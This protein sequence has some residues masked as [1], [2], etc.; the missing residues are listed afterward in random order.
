MLAGAAFAKESVTEAA[1]QKTF[2]N[3]VRPFV[4]TYCIGCHGHEKPKGDFDLSPFTSMSAVVADFKHWEL[5]LERLEAKEMPPKK[6]EK[7]P[8]AAQ[9]KEITDW[10]LALRRFE[11]DRNAGDPG[12]VLARRLSNAEYDF[13]IRDLTGV[14]IRPTR[15]FPVDPANQAGFDNSGESLTMSPAL[16]KKYLQAAKD[17]SDHLLLRPDGLGFAPHPVVT[18]TDRD[19]YCIRQIVDFYLRQP[20][21]FADYFAAAWR[22]KNRSALGKSRAAIE[23]IAADAKV[24]PK[25]LA[26]VWGALIAK[27]EVGPIAKLQTM[28]RELPPAKRGKEPEELRAACVAMRDFVVDVREKIK[29][30]VKNLGIPGVN[31]SAQ[32][33][34]LWKDRQMAA[35]RTKYDP[36]LLQIDGAVPQREEDKNKGPSYNQ[37]KVAKKRVLPDENLF[38][39]SAERAKYEAAFARFAAIFP[40]A[41]YVKE[42]G[43]TFVDPEEEKANGNVGRL[44]SAGLHNQTGY[45]RDDGPLYNMVLDAKGQREL[46]QLWDEFNLIASVPQRMHQSTV[47]FERTD[48]RF[49]SGAEFDFARA[50]DKDCSSEAKVRKLAELYYAKAE[51]VGASETALAAVKEHFERVIANVNRVEKMAVDAEPKHLEAL[52]RF[53][54]RAFRRPLRSEERDG[55]LSFYKNLRAQDGLTHEEAIRDTLASVLMSPNYLYRVDLLAEGK[56]VQ[57]LDDYALASRLSYFL[58]SSLPDETLL[59]RAAAGDLHKPTVLIAQTRRMLKDPRARALATEFLASWLDFR[60]FEELNSVDRNRFP[61]FDNA[62]RQAMYEEPIHFFMDV[63]QENRSALDF[64]Y[65]KSTFVNSALAKHYGIPVSGLGTN[66]WV[67]VED[68]RKFERGGILPMAVFLTK[69]APGLRTSP[70]KRGY[71]VVRRVLGEQI[72]PPPPVVPELPAD[73]SK[74]GELTLRDALARH[75]EDKACAGCHARF[76]SY[77]LVFENFGPIGERRALD[78]GGKP[79]D[80]RA[81]FSDGSEESGI[82]GLRHYLKAHREEDFLNTLC[83]QLLAFGLNRTLIVSDDST[84]REM[85]AKLAAN[86]HRFDTLVENVVTSPQ[87]LNKRGQESLAKN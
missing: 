38:V 45:F 79:V 9:R 68:A 86:G 44:L 83:R 28:F 33:L 80:I 25:Y 14:D 4:D 19:K 16:V 55:L 70:V 73:E 49:L 1:L 40:D 43:R 75:R 65:G 78:L 60:R 52:A 13:T 51:R 58:W 29:P 62:L 26:T 12:I 31:A 84:I 32:A 50:E 61:Q 23:Q 36:A 8:T 59:A 54:E 42:R 2:G 64:L 56:A 85:R 37:K 81:Q 39:P 20:T 35:N 67:R 21:D 7:H 17:V 22:Y 18:E 53:A 27:E 11:A 66:E 77:G 46:D 5:A 34:V 71:W 6:A 87:F 76:D 69:N 82:E 74:L 3:T 47:Y 41:F 57:P 30:E 24:S 63:I 48:S 10:I 15:E 72:P